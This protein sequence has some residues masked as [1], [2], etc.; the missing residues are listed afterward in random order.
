MKPLLLLAALAAASVVSAPVASAATHAVE[1]AWV[2]GLPPDSLQRS[3]FLEGFQSTFEQDR[4][5]R[6]ISGIAGWSLYSPMANAFRLCR[7]GTDRDAWSL[8]VNLTLPPIASGTRTTWRT[9][10]SGK[11]VVP[12]SK[13]WTNPKRRSTRRMIVRVVALTSNQAR[14]G[15]A[16]APDEVPV[17]FPGPAPSAEGTPVPPLR[18]YE[19]P[20]TLA[21]RTAGL[22]ALESL[23]HR[24]RD[25]GERERLAL[26]HVTRV[27][28]QE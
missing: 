1:V 19:F 6:E 12:E 7:P 18:G 28:R 8:R 27:D 26:P 5:E 24:S 21:G 3:Q 17:Q 14:I 23:H 11:Y 22:L 10:P 2:Q 15:D 25:L 9:D 4:L 20:W 16:P 13:G